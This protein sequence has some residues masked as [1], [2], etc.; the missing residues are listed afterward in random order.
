MYPFA[1]ARPGQSRAA[2]MNLL[3]RIVK[4]MSLD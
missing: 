2:K 3:A 4:N 1:E